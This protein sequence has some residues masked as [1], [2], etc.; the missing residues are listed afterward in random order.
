[1]LGTT[2][3]YLSSSCNNTKGLASVSLC[4]HGNCI[5]PLCANRKKLHSHTS[6]TSTSRAL[7]TTLHCPLKYQGPV[8]KVANKPSSLSGSWLLG[9]RLRQ[10]HPQT[11]PFRACGTQLGGVSTLQ[12]RVQRGLHGHLLGSAAWPGSIWWQLWRPWG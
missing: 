2:H 3:T 6:L 10:R 8:T 1:M 7:P 5:M 9:G 12:G 11:L 4:R